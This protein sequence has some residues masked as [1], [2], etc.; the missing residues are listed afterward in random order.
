M[1]GGTFYKVSGTS[2]STPALGGLLSN[3]NAA[4]MATGKGS[5]GFINPT[6]YAN[7]TSFVNDITS[8]NN[9]CSA[10]AVCCAQGFFAT[11]GWDPASGLGSIDYGKM[12]ALFLSLG[13]IG[14]KVVPGTDPTNNPTLRPSSAPTKAIY[15]IIQIRQVFLYFTLIYFVVIAFKL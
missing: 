11:K 14:E 3:I 12:Q 7:Y 8:G 2:A 1:I 4:R 13:E 9:R 15:S 10:N 6:L 5:I